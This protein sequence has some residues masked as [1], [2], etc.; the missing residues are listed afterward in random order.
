MLDVHYCDSSFL[1][2]KSHNSCSAALLKVFAPFDGWYPRDSQ[3]R[4]TKDVPVCLSD[5]VLLYEQNQFEKPMG[6]KYP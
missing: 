4:N 6:L 3:W 5:S 1:Y 2:W